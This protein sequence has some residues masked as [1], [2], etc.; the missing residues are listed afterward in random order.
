MK[1]SIGGGGKRK[2]YKLS[3]GMTYLTHLPLDRGPVPGR[4][5]Q[6]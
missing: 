5:G 1:K 4:Q 6:V 3:P 2:E